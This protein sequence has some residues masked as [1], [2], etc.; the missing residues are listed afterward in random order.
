MISGSG[1]SRCVGVQRVERDLGQGQRPVAGQRDLVD[2]RLARGSAYAWSVLETTTCSRWSTGTWWATAGSATVT[3]VGP[4]RG[5]SG[6]PDRG[7]GEL[8]QHRRAGPGAWSD[9][10][11]ALSTSGPRSHSEANRVA[12]VRA[13]GDLQVD[14]A[15]ADQGQRALQRLGGEQSRP[16]RAARRARTRPTLDACPPAPRRCPAGWSAPPGCRR[17]ARARSARRR[18]GP[19]RCSV[20]RGPA[21]RVRGSDPGLRIAGAALTD[22][23]GLRHQHRERRCPAVEPSSLQVAAE[24]VA[25]GRPAARRPT[26]R[27]RGRPPPRSPGPVSRRQPAQVG[28][29]LVEREQGVVLAGD[30][31]RR[32]GD[33]GQQA[34]RTGLVEQCGQR[35]GSGR[36]DSAAGEIARAQRGGEPATDRV[37]GRRLGPAACRRC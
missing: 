18:P 8:R 31:Q 12:I 6:E 32:R 4:A 3:A 29:G 1:T 27:R 21:A 34:L 15:A 37:P 17:A 20:R 22:Q 10:H 11:G 23:R 28:V 5:E 35:R 13:G 7:H 19:S 30:D 33:L 26:G 24:P 9:R 2:R 16:D 14:P 25:S 36:P